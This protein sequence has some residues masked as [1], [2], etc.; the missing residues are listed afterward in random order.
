M[1]K[2]KRERNRTASAL[3]ELGL[4]DASAGSAKLPEPE[5]ETTQSRKAFGFLKNH[6]WFAGLI[7]VLS[8]GVFGAGIRY[9]VMTS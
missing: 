1:S 7:V 6:L 9:R 2:R 8:I 3:I 4:T 5:A